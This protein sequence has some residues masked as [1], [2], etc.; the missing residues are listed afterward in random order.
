[1][2]WPWPF[3]YLCIL[4]FIQDAHDGEVNAIQWSS[5]GNLFASGS[6]DRKIKL[7]EYQGGQCTCK[8]SLLGSNAGITAIEFDYEV[9]FDNSEL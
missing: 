3:G 1:M 2:N 6:S 7:W 5:S 4:I 8:G 9:N